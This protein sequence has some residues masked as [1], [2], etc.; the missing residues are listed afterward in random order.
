GLISD[1]CTAST[2]F[3]LLS[4]LFD[5]ITLDQCAQ[6]FKYLDKNVET[7]KSEM[8]Y[9][10]GK[11]YL[12]R[13]CNDLL[14]RLSKSRN[15]VFCGQIQLFLAHLFPLEEKSGLNLM[16]NFNMENMISYNKNPDQCEFNKK[17]ICKYFC[18]VS[19][20]FVI[21]VNTFDALIILSDITIDYNLYKKFWTLQE[22]FKNP[23]R[24]YGTGAWKT[25]T[26]CASG[27]FGCFKSF[28]LSQ[29]KMPADNQKNQNFKQEC[30]F[31]KYL[32]SDKLFNLQL[33]DSNFRRNVLVQFLI[34]F[35]YLT[36][37]VKFKL[38]GHV[39]SEDQ[40]SWIADATKTV[41]ELLEETPTDG[42]LF[43]KTVKH[44]LDR[45]ENWIAW[46][47]DGCASFIKKKNAPTQNIVPPHNSRKRNIGMD[48]KSNSKVMKLGNPEMT[49]LWNLCLDNELA[50]K[51]QDRNFVADMSVYFSQAMEQLD[52]SASIEESYKLIN[53]S[54]FAWKSLRLLAS[55]SP[56]FFSQ[57]HANAT[58]IKNI[59]RYLEL[60]LNKLNKELPVIIEDKKITENNTGS[61]SSSQENDDEMMASDEQFQDFVVKIGNNW[62]AL[63]RIVLKDEG[64]VK[65]IEEQN[66]PSDES[67][68]EVIDEWKV[69]G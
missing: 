52:P 63:A 39:L 16:S 22:Y 47:N 15:T 56:A 13:M 4:D 68:F 14:R 30:C 37:H 26:G 42:E 62:K 53:N 31:A 27:V 64:V 59:P 38:S 19:I 51:S 40:I 45:E 50:C 23:T 17:K 5:M 65:E 32:T 55:Q 2:L 18:V 48:L 66:L 60:M 21:M 44:T 7:W 43:A 46:K 34:L 49:K 57:M 9:N 24:C 41:Y 29:V 67:C 20:E 10:A 25:F 33:S 54:T 11:N 8:F 3:I 36:S 28:K 35:Q 61:E 1:V 12:L 58:P 6:L 69:T